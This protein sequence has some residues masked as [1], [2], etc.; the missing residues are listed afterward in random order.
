M[1]I[2]VIAIIVLVA[3]FSFFCGVVIGVAWVVNFNEE[4]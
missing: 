2:S 4:K 1:L 3:V